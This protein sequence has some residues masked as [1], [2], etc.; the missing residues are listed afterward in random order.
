[1]LEGAMRPSSCASTPIVLFSRS[2][3]AQ[4]DIYALIVR[5]QAC[6]IEHDY[7]NPVSQN[8]SPRQSAR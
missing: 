1:M 8:A 2:I 4:Q 6:V 3:F 7:G 5:L